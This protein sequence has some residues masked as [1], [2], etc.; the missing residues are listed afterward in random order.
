MIWIE[1]GIFLRGSG[2]QRVSLKLYYIY[3]TIRMK[4]K[5]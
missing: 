4:T 5:S 1:L 2:I 3:K